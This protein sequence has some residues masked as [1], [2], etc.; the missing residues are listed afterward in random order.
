MA[1]T[2]KRMTQR[3][4]T[5]K[6][7][8]HKPPM[9]IRVEKPPIWD[10]CDEAFELTGDEIFCWGDIIYNPGGNHIPD[11]LVAHEKVHRD[12]QGDDIEGWWEL[13]LEDAEFRLSQEMEAHIKEYRV[14]CLKYK[15]RK[16]REAYL[17]IIAERLASPMYGEVITVEEAMARIA[18]GR[19]MPQ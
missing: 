6:G 7:A 3:K 10:A 9:E 13:Y 1:Q 11:Y 2:R 14:F 15:L 16:H 4:A 18:A 8:T 5:K 19:K 12:Q 17:K